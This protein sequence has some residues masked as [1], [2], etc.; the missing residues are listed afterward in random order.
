MHMTL[1]WTNE[2]VVH[3]IDLVSLVDHQDHCQMHDRVFVRNRGIY[4]TGI[5]MLG[6]FV[7][8][9]DVNKMFMV[10]NN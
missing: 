8:N 2:D 7:K 4:S 3:A 1:D 9:V 10:M 6:L 5:G